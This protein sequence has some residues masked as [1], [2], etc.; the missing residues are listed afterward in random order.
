MEHAIATLSFYQ[1]RRNRLEQRLKQ[2]REIIMG[3][4]IRIFDLVA[5]VGGK[6]LLDCLRATTN[7]L[8]EN[9]D[10]LQKAFYVW[11]YYDDG[12]NGYVCE[13]WN[14]SAQE[15]WARLV[16]DAPTY[17]DEM[18]KKVVSIDLR[19]LPTT[20][21]SDE[22]DLLYAFYYCALCTCMCPAFKTDGV[23]DWIV[24]QSFECTVGQL[25]ALLSASAYI[26][27]QAGVQDDYKR[28]AKAAVHED[29]QSLTHADLVF[30]ELSY[31]EIVERKV[32]QKTTQTFYNFNTDGSRD[33][34][35]YL[36]ALF[37]SHTG[38][39]PCTL[40]DPKYV[41]LVLDSPAVKE[42]TDSLLSIDDMQTEW[43]DRACLRTLTN[44]EPH[45]WHGMEDVDRYLAAYE[46]LKTCDES[47]LKNIVDKNFFYNAINPMDEFGQ[48]KRIPSP[49]A[50]KQLSHNE[51]VSILKDVLAQCVEHEQSVAREAQIIGDTALGEME[52]QLDDANARLT[53]VAADWLGTTNV[54]DELF[55]QYAILRER[56]FG[57]GMPTGANKSWF[58]VD[59]HRWMPVGPVE[60]VLGALEMLLGEEDMSRSMDD[61]LYIRTYDRL[62][63]A[64]YYLDSVLLRRMSR[65][66]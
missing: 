30:R 65:N 33:V 28:D 52:Q 59:P 15:E 34:F 19:T 13:E 16:K 32:A 64:K 14:S 39:S 41:A 60:L 31:D 27:S 4:D 61:E 1:A 45:E 43:N 48:E 20:L 5:H 11:G 51:R 63:E 7:K 6:D 10:E 37:V 44:I 40:E 58:V 18:L 24:G 38:K 49:D 22:R 23:E 46:G 21:S 9:T 62:D 25:R 26:E 42:F 47:A 12:I 35:N 56:Y 36:D 17:S 57:V 50:W 53:E 29:N 66:S 3:D 55:A 8:V 2:I 54:A